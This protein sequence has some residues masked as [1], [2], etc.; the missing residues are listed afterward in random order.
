MISDKMLLLGL[1]FLTF[2]INYNEL[3]LFKIIDKKFPPHNNEKKNL[4]K[5]YK[6]RP[7]TWQC[8]SLYDRSF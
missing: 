4:L 6:S 2:M 1:C 5:V 8:D 7:A 3:L